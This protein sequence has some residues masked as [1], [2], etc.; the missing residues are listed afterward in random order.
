MIAA[1]AWASARQPLKNPRRPQESVHRK[2]T[3]SLTR[4]TAATTARPT[5]AQRWCFLI[6]LV[7]FRKKELHYGFC[8][9]CCVIHNLIVESRRHPAN[10]EARKTRTKNGVKKADNVKNATLLKG[11]E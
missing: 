8:W 11:V 9:N 3:P 5:R 6:L 2:A 10:I 1:F 4:P 7:V